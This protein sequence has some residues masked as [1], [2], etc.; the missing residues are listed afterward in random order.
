MSKNHPEA[1]IYKGLAHIYDEIMRDIDYDDWADFID[2]IIQT[3]HPEAETLLELACGTG[4]HALSLDELE[5]YEIT[6]TDV[7]NEMLEVAKTKSIFKQSEIIWQQ[8]D[9]TSLELDSKF[10]VIMML[11][12]SIN[13]VVDPKLVVQVLD[14]VASHLNENGIFVFD[15]TTPANSESGADS[16]NDEGTTPDDYR[17]ERKSYYLPSERIHYNEF[18]IERLSED[19]KQVLEHF[20]EIHRQR[21]YTLQEMQ[22]LVSQSKLNLLAAYAELD[23]EDADERSHRITMVLK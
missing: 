22:E 5:T 12:D 19:K 11:F 14:R 7:S 1:E 16:M 21:I 10:D 15:F 8:A 13:Y 2:E 4:N 23:F 3:H 20:R 17:Y 6:A 18:E 9:F